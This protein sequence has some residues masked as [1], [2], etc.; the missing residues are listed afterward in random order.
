VVGAVVWS[1]GQWYLLSGQTTPPVV[2]SPTAVSQQIPTVCPGFK[3]SR[4]T[5]GRTAHITP[6]AA[7]NIRSIASTKGVLLGQIPAGATLSVLEG[8]TCA[9]NLA[10][11]RVNYNGIIGWTAEGADNT[12]WMRPGAIATIAPDLAGAVLE[13][14]QTAGSVVAYAGLSQTSQELDTLFWGDRVLWE[15]RS[16]A[17]EN[18]NWLEVRLGN[19]QTAYVI[20]HPGSFV[21]E[22]PGFQT[23]GISLNRTVGVTQLGDAMNLR[24]SASTGSALVQTLPAGQ[25]LTVIGGPAYS[26]Y[27]LWWNYRLPDGRTGWAVDVA[28]WLTPQ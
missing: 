13:L 21:V 24:V 12:Y 26:E 5:A 17:A 11:W 7:N 22:D 10:W 4:L 18:L 1:Y 23:V 3:V 19:G 14:T 9:D 28:G 25:G 15:G 27:Y 2:T 20:N 8:P 16:F 6:G